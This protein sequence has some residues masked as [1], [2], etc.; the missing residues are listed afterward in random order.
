MSGFQSKRRA[1]DTKRILISG[2]FL[3]LTFP[4]VSP[5][6][7]DPLALFRGP[8]SD[9]TPVIQ[10]NDWSE[11]VLFLFCWN[12]GA[13]MSGWCRFSARISSVNSAAREI[14]PWLSLM[15][16]H[17][18]HKF[19][20]YLTKMF[21]DELL[22]HQIKIWVLQICTNLHIICSIHMFNLLFC[23]RIVFWLN[24]K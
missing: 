13:S 17:L 14:R 4:S 8:V 24:D 16:W 2:S 12:T 19:W 10:K 9:F 18:P 15:F 6:D 11:F 22:C 21:S 5:K 23:I 20:Y 1:V 7:I 3:F